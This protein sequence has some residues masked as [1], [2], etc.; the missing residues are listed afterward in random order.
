MS[1]EF[2]AKK[3]DALMNIFEAAARGE[4]TSHMKFD[5]YAQDPNDWSWLGEL[6]PGLVVSS[7]GGLVPFQAEG[8]LKGHP[9]YYR[10]RHGQARLNIAELEA[11]NAYLDNCIYTAYADVDEFRCGPE[12]ITTFLNLVER[13][14]RAPFLYKFEGNEVKFKNPETKGTTQSLEDIYIDD[15]RTVHVAWGDSPEEALE[16]SYESGKEVLVDHYGWD[17]A[18]YNR[19]VELEARNPVPLNVDDR[20][21]PDPDFEVRVPESWRNSDG[22]IEIPADVWEEN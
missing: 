8:L 14:K 7:A 15:E 21:I 4:D 1:E 3:K 17:L 5:M 16:F 12:W 11:D 9:F 10:E 18:F 2:D 13:L 19:M 22:E 6:V 20:V